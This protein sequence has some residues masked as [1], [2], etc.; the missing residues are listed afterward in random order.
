MLIDTVLWNNI[1]VYAMDA[2]KI[3]ITYV[4]NDK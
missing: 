3:Y 4:L 1:E 2:S